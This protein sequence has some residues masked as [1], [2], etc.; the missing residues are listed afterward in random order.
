MLL[1]KFVRATKSQKYGY[2]ILVGQK[3]EFL[4]FHLPKARYLSQLRWKR[5]RWKRDLPF[6][7]HIDVLACLNILE[8]NWTGFM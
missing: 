1:N 5:S 3:V 7:Q 8:E 6:L 2:V 4:L